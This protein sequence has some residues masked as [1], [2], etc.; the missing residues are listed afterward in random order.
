M[1]FVLKGIMMQSFWSNEALYEPLPVDK[2]RQF[3][4]NDALTILETYCVE[5]SGIG[6][7]F[8]MIKS[9]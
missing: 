5:K 7:N 6:P 8:S 1:N 3:L 2:Q 4:E 9:G